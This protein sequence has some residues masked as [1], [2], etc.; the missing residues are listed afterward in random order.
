MY[1]SETKPPLLLL[2]QL[3][4]ALINA[5]QSHQLLVRADFRNFAIMQHHNS[6]SID[7]RRQTMCDNQRRAAFSQLVQGLLNPFSFSV[8]YCANPVSSTRY[9]AFS[10]VYLMY[11]S[12]GAN[13]KK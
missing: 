9:M 1:F 4:K 3:I 7:N 10:I 11:L 8:L 5:A 12:S 2:V 6:V 13:V